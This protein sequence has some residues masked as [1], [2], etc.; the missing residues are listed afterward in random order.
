MALGV[1]I[2]LGAMLTAAMIL[3]VTKPVSAR[4][5]VLYPSSVEIIFVLIPILVGTSMALSG[6]NMFHPSGIPHSV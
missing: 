4:E 5:Y 6:H 1:D 3:Q 2:R